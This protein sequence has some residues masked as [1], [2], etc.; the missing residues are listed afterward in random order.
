M[1]APFSSFAQAVSLVHSS[2]M[3]YLLEYD[4]WGRFAR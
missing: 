1:L 4:L 3:K 2:N